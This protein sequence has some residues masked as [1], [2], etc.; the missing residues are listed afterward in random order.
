[1]ATILELAINCDY[2]TLEE[3]GFYGID[4]SLEESLTE[5]HLAIKPSEQYRGEFTILYSVPHYDGENR[6]WMICTLPPE[7][8][9][10]K[11]NESWFDKSAF[12]SFVDSTESIWLLMPLVSQIQ[13]LISYYGVDNIM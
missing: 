5:Y 9:T 10:D 1:M 7:H 11:I 4:A 12:F 3:L 8:F 2:D 13:D 6:V